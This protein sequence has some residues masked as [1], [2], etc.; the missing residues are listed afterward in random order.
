MSYS[1]AVYTFPRSLRHP[2]PLQTRSN[3]SSVLLVC[4]SWLQ[5]LTPGVVSEA[6]RTSR[7]SLTSSPARSRK[8]LSYPQILEADRSVVANHLPAAVGPDTAV[9]TFNARGI[10]KSEGSQPWPGAYPGNDHLDFAAVEEAGRDLTGAEKIYRLV[11]VFLSSA[12]HSSSRVF[13]GCLPS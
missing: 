11:S 5:P 7:E 6:T 2:R 10:G 9:L 8:S 1:N 3:R 13:P 4:A 12:A